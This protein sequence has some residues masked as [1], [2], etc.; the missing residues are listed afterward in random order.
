MNMKKCLEKEMLIMFKFISAKS[1]KHY[2]DKLKN[3]LI[4]MEMY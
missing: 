4:S 3:G 1:Q 2:K